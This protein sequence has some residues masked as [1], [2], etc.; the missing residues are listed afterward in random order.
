MPKSHEAGMC[1]EQPEALTSLPNSQEFLPAYHTARST[2]QLTTQPEALT[3]Q[4]GDIQFT[5]KEH[6]LSKNQKHIPIYQ[7]ARGTYHFTCQGY[8]PIFKPKTLT[9]WYCQ[10]LPGAIISLP[11]SQDLPHSHSQV[12]QATKST[13]KFTK[14]PAYQ[15]TSWCTNL[16][17]YQT[18]M[19]TCQFISKEHLT[20]YQTTTG[21]YLLPIQPG[22]LSNYKTARN[23]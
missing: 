22:A 4:Y 20:I 13:C 11:S 23:T 12:Y 10:I 3:N 16:P 6:C 5:S 8:L 1:T 7:T 14:Q 15:T 9:S 21:I 17:V 2:Y 19:C 18:A